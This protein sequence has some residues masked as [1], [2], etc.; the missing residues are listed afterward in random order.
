MVGEPFP[1]GQHGSVSRITPYP[2]GRIFGGPFP[3][4]SYLATFILSLWDE[5]RLR[6]SASVSFRIVMRLSFRRSRSF[7]LVLARFSRSQLH[8]ASQPFLQ[9][10]G[11]E[12]FGI[13]FYGR[14]IPIENT[15]LN[16]GAIPFPSDSE[17]SL[18]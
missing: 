9:D 16:S 18:Q 7:P 11:A 4:T 14:F 8:P 2:P 6:K 5:V 1:R 13:E 15:P 10:L 17:Q 3:G 12:P